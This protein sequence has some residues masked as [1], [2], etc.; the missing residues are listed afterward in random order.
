MI[1]FVALND[2]FSLWLEALRLPDYKIIELIKLPRSQT[3]ADIYKQRG[4]K[5]DEF[6][7]QVHRNFP[8]IIKVMLT[9]QADNDAVENA[10][11]KVGDATLAEMKNL[12]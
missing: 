6:L 5:G 3:L 11:K 10:K 9:G 1:I 8:K 7:I 2:P 4:I 12:N